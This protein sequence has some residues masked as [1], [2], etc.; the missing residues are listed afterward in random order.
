MTQILVMNISSRARSGGGELV[1]N[2]IKIINFTMMALKCFLD[3]PYTGSK[4]SWK[5]LFKWAFGFC[6][7]FSATTSP[8]PSARF[9]SVYESFFQTLMGLG[10]G[11][12]R[13]RFLA[14]VRQSATALDSVIGGLSPSSQFS[15]LVFSEGNKGGEV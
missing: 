6:R 5:W 12:F 9:G 3:M 13:E 11:G 7:D 4:S 15:A 14:T 1:Q 10:V 2:W 8:G